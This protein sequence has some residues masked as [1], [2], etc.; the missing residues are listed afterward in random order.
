MY[1][2]VLYKTGPSVTLLLYRFIGKVSEGAITL[3]LK[4]FTLCCAIQ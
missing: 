2:K 3:F 1:R 4:T